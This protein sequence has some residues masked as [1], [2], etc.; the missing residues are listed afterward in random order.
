MP[1]PRPSSG[2]RRSTPPGVMGSGR[3]SAKGPD[4]KRSRLLVVAA[5]AILLVAVLL[6]A[7]RG[8][9]PQAPPLPGI[10]RP[11][12]AQDPFGFESSRTP[13]FEARA[14]AGSSHVLFV[15]SPGGAEAT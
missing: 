9:G 15:K 8:G 10:G 3:P 1:R 2:G 12:R 14:A 13:A 5:A 6:A 11:A 4:W 7:L